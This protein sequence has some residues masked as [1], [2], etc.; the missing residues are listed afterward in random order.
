MVGLT[1]IKKTV[2]NFQTEA[3]RFALEDVAVWAPDLLSLKN[4]PVGKLGIINYRGTFSGTVYDFA[5]KGKLVTAVGSMA[6]DFKLKMEGP[7]KGYTGIIGN[8]NF[9]GGKLLDLKD[10]GNLKF[11]G[12]VSSSGFSGRDPLKVKGTISSGEYAGYTYKNIVA[13]A[14]LAGKKFTAALSL[15]DE[16]LAG[17]FETV[18]DFNKTGTRY[19]GRGILRTADLRAL[20]FMK[21]SLQ[22]SGEFDVDFKGKTID[23]FLG[24]ARFYNGKIVAGNSPLSFD[25][26]LLQSEIDTAGV[27]RLSLHTNEADLTVEGKFNISNIGNGLQY[28]LNRYYPAIIKPLGKPVA[29]QDVYFHLVTREVEPFLGC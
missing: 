24:Y 23:D 9:D 29:N 10:L 7:G 5:A 17:T 11:S 26:L 28:F 21:D 14:V 22:F 25:S 15:D 16:N 6:A 2:I 4:T 18:L 1:D 3:S 19:N 8:A 20:G 27:K 12:T 13:D